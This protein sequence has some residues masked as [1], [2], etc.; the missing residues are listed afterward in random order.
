MP[1]GIE[2]M[3]PEAAEKVPAPWGAVT[4]SRKCGSSRK[5]NGW[6]QSRNILCSDF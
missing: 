6:D 5:K 4:N 1:R 2:Q 3:F